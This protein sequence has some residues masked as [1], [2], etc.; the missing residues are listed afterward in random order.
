VPEPVHKAFHV[1]LQLLKE[2][3]NLYKVNLSYHVHRDKH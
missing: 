1:V 3:L 2:L